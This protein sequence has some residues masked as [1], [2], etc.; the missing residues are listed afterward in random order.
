MSSIAKPLTTREP[1][2]GGT[3]I[4]LS[5]S[6]SGDRAGTSTGSAA[7]ASEERAGT[8]DSAAA[9]LNVK[10]DVESSSK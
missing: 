3:K 5:S 8:R 10:R 6:T 1:V 7:A 4:S 2:N 9:V